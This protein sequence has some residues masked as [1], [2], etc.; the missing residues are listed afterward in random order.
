[1]KSFRGMTKLSMKEQLECTLP[2]WSIDF[3][4]VK[5]DEI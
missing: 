5:F 1:M 2:K 3:R 4:E